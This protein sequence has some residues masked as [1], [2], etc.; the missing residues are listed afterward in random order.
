MC[1]IIKGVCFLTL[2][3]NPLDTIKN[4]NTPGWNHDNNFIEDW[5]VLLAKYYSNSKERERERDRGQ[6]KVKTDPFLYFYL[7]CVLTLQKAADPKWRQR[8]Y[9]SGQWFK[10]IKCIHASNKGGAN[11]NIYILYIYIP[12]RDIRFILWT[13]MRLTHSSSFAHQGRPVRQPCATPWVQI[14]SNFKQQE[15]TNI[16]T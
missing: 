6:N 5:N 10:H 4:W 14:K 9:R 15:K 13:T 16:T 1:S 2:L 12:Q 11:I 7:F 8:L 3:N